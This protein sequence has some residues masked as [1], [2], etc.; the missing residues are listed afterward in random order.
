MTKYA[1]APLSLSL[2]FHAAFNDFITQDLIAVPSGFRLEVLV[3]VSSPPFL[4]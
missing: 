2:S 3:G 4:P 1:K